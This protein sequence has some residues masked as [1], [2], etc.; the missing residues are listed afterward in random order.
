MR[1][2]VQRPPL[3]KALTDAIRIFGVLAALIVFDKVT[4]DDVL[5]AVLTMVVCGGYVAWF[6]WTHRY[7]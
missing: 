4:G 7:Q 3:R 6:F 5:T 2:T 1:T